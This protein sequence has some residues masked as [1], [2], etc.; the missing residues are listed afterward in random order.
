MDFF[1][2]SCSLPGPAY[3]GRHVQTPQGCESD[4][5]STASLLHSEKKMF[6]TCRICSSYFQG[7]AGLCRTTIVKF[8]ILRYDNISSQ[9][10]L[11]K[12][13]QI[14]QKSKIKINKVKNLPKLFCA[15]NPRNCL[16]LLEHQEALMWCALSV[17]YDTNFHQL[18]TQS[19]K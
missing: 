18:C 5:T 7:V 19:A 9:N 11:C 14:M 2:Y 4:F 3:P 12:C 13:E 8:V 10:M 15:R 6:R 1:D 16:C 17:T